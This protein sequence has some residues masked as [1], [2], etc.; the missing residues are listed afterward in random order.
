MT[1]IIVRTPFLVNVF[2]R[3][4]VDDHS[5]GLKWETIEQLNVKTEV[6][7]LVLITSV[8]R[9]KFNG[10]NDEAVDG[11]LIDATDQRM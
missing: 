1:A 4:V 2:V 3:N 7:E 9:Q 6:K 8:S 5:D 10:Y 11:G